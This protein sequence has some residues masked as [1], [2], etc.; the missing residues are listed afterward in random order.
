MTRRAER[1]RPRHP[2]LRRNRAT[3]EFEQVSGRTRSP[4]S[5]RACATRSPP[6]P[7]L[8]RLVHG[9]PGR[10]QLLAR[11][12]GQGLPRR[13]RLAALL[14]G[15]LAGRRQP[16]RRERAA[17]RLAA[18]GPDPRPAAH[19]LPADGR[20]EPVRLARQRP[21][22]AAGQEPAARDRRARRARRRR[23]PA[24]HRDGPAL[25]A[26]RGA[27]RHR[28]LAAAVDPAC[29]SRRASPTRPRWRARPPAGRG[30]ASRACLPAG[31]DRR[32]HRRPGGGRARARPRLRRRGPRAPSTAHRL[33]PRP[34]RHARRLPA[35]R[36]DARHRQPRP[37][38]RRR[39]RPPAVA[40]DEVEQA[41]LDTY[42]KVRSRS[43]ASP[44]CSGDLPASLLARRSRRRRGPDARV[45]RERRQPGAV[46]PDGDALEA[47]LGGPRP[48]VS[49]DF[50]VNE[51]NRHADY[52]LPARPCSSAT[53]C[54]SPSSAS[55]RRRSCSTR[56]PWSPRAARRAR[57]G[58][59]STI[60]REIGAAAVRAAGAARAR[61]AR[62][63]DDAAAAGRPAAAHR[64]RRRPLRPAPRRPVAEGPAQAAARD[65]PLRASRPACLGRVRHAD[66]KSTSTIRR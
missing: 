13:P 22:R 18:A 55:T 10:L 26:R 4:T 40:L 43:A 37:R 49:L 15:L 21:H 46:V 17:L 56:T 1:P 52:V 20:R 2:P 24:P 5:A 9:Q 8:G 34:L 63:P 48:D 31:A 7:R 29:S 66:H 27:P 57:S 39:V 62:L 58:E 53:T 54:R 32:A 16:L 64:P 14:H 47:A 38:R 41:G 50:Y 42:G 36:A 6:R 25:R 19:E 35:R 59:S 45:L 44:T 11:A 12:V 61:A 60:S 51:T 23:R 30:L 65:R 28:R 33:V 3:G